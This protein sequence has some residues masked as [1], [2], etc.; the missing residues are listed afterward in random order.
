VTASPILGAR[1]A[2]AH[3]ESALED[4]ADVQSFVGG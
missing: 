2:V 4:L 1:F 3:A